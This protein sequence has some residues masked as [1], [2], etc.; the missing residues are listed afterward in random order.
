MAELSED[1]AAIEAYDR[2]GEA[3]RAAGHAVHWPDLALDPDNLV[4][5]AEGVIGSRID[6][7][8][9]AFGDDFEAEACA[10][11]IE[12]AWRTDAFQARFAP[13]GVF[14]RVEFTVE[15]ALLDAPR[16][17]AEPAIGADEPDAARESLRVAAEFCLSFVEKHRTRPFI[18]FMGGELRRESDGAARRIEPYSFMVE[19]GDAIAWGLNGS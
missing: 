11:R 6:F 2:A 9:A 14:V 1:R 5:L 8:R 18:D 17:D 10:D 3:S 4:R 15:V 19:P 16:S 13:E 7:A 12:E